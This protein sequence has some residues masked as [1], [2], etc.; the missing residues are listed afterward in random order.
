MGKIWAREIKI[1]KN[2]MASVIFVYREYL[3][4]PYLSI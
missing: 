1:Q 4:Y 3:P 2:N